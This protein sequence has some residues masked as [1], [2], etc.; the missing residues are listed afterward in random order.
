MILCMNL[1]LVSATLFEV[2]PF[3]NR[4][5]PA[6]TGTDPLFRFRMNH[7]TVDLLIPGVGML[8]TAYHLGRQLAS[9]NYDFAVN[10]GIA[11]SFRPEIPIGSVVEVTEDCVTELGA[12][13][14]GGIVSFFELG[15]MDPDAHPYRRGKL[16]NDLPIRVPAL[17]K[18]RMVTG[19]TVNTIH[20]SADGVKR[21]RNQSA[22]DV[23]TM[24]GAAFLFAC[25]SA[26]IPSTQIRSISN[27][28]DERD[29][30]KWDVKLALK[31]LNDVLK[32]V[33]S[34]IADS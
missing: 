19:S 31:N 12:E 7:H 26:G 32:E 24:E 30:A 18:L 14:E 33:V 5:S 23:E 8:M 16:V 2:R 20:G 6:G 28:V 13:E 10:A 4:L 27:F 17:E 3:I 29:K 9:S 1:L 34:E 25:L 21:V 22:A 15:L 11:G